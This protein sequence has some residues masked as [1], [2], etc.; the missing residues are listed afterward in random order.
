M[1]QALTAYQQPDDLGLAL[2]ITPE[3]AKRRLTELQQFVKSVMVDGDDYGI[4]P[5]TAKPTLFKP[6]AEKLC[7]IYGLAPVVDVTHRIEDWDRGFFHY[8]VRTQLV[9][10]RTG[11]VV[12]VGVGSCN[13]K[14]ERYRWRDSKRKCPSCGKEAIIKGKAEYGGGWLCF[15]RQG[16]CG[17]KYN[18]GDAAIEGQSAGRIENPDPY[19][20]VNTILKMAK[21][22]SLVDATLSATRSSALFTQDM[23]DFATP[24]DDGGYIPSPRQQQQQA[25]RANDSR[26]NA[27]AQARATGQGNDTATPAQV[28]AIYAIGRR[29]F[30]W[31]D[32]DVDTHCHSVYGKA[33]VQL[34][35]RE[36][37]ELIDRLKTN[38][39]S[40]A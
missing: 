15:A 37:S 34:S 14:E 26:N 3:E 30:H 40:I 16:G 38:P 20:L 32:E 8:E 36:A 24:D 10:K 6:G 13:S 25:A 27:A 28:N 21:K 5:G 31:S 35:K 17:A 23:E 19:T 18:D 1:T 11:A 39:A 4:I 12:A 29:E 7:E 22:R 9:S 2:V 33:A